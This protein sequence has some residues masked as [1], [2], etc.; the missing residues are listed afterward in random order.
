MQ[1]QDFKRSKEKEAKE[2][3]QDEEDADP[4]TKPKA[5]GKAKAKGK[6]RARKQSAA[7]AKAK[8]SPNKKKGRGKKAP[9]EIPAPTT[10][11]SRKSEVPNESRSKRK[12]VDGEVGGVSK[13]AKKTFARRYRPAG[14]SGGNVWDA[15][16]TAFVGIVSVQLS[17][18]AIMEV[19]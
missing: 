13:W 5:K 14:E 9:E 16:M 11:V 15:L 8:S 18:P 17:A 7:K 12:L 4:K 1:Q 19:G 6:S 3:E 2:G 10:P